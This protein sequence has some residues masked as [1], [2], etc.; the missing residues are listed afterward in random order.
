MQRLVYSRVSN[1][2]YREPEPVRVHQE[3]GQRDRHGSYRQFLHRPG[4][5]AFRLASGERRYTRV[6]EHHTYHETVQAN[7]SF[8]RPED[9]HP[10]VPRIRQRIDLVGLL[11]GPWHCDLRQSG[12]LRGTYPVQSEE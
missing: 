11:L 5:T 1:T 12:L 10:D 6:L 9:S 3:L 2:D 4:A 8:V 7:P